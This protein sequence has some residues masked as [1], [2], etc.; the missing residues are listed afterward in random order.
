MFRRI[1]FILAIPFAALI[2]F[3]AAAWANVAPG[4]Y[5]PAPGS[6]NPAN[7]PGSSHLAS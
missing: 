2:A 3:S 1:L 7:A 6:F 4:T 5:T